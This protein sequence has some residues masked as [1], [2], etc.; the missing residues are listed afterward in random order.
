MELWLT[1]LVLLNLQVRIDAEPDL[2]KG[3]YDCASV[4]DTSAEVCLLSNVEKGATLF[5]VVE[6]FTDFED[7]I[8][9]CYSY[10]DGSVQEAMEL[11]P[12]VALGPFHLRTNQIKD[13]TYQTASD[14]DFICA[15]EGETGDADLFLQWFD[16][17]ILAVAEG[18]AQYDCASES[19]SSMETCTIENTK[20]ATIVWARVQAFQS[21]DD[22]LITCADAGAAY[23]EGA[24]E[25]VTT[26]EMNE[27][28]TLPNGSVGEPLLEDGETAEANLEEEVTV[29]VP[30]TT[31]K[32][33]DSS[34][35]DPTNAPAET[36]SEATGLSHYLYLPVL[37]LLCSFH[38]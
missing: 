22:V 37:L 2:K 33:T 15:L 16:P 3:L 17:P 35:K 29:D 26:P 21:F 7:L 28:E 18:Q 25:E 34:S 13:F 20:G 9:A 8:L 12:G 5:V 19:E 30:V 11:L 38:L 23:G 6:A 10:S 1:F 14:S 31:E 24:K 36:K 4:G 27:T 32:E